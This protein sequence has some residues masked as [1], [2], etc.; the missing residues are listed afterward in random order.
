M[1]GEI[2]NGGGGECSR[3][4]SIPNFSNIIPDGPVYS[5]RCFPGSRAESG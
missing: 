5:K 4:R 3:R 1:S 2:I